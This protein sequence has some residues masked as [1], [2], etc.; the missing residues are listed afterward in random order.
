MSECLPTKEQRYQLNQRT[1][2]KKNIHY[3]ATEQDEDY[4]DYSENEVYIRQTQWPK[5][6]NTDRRTQKEIAKNSESKKEIRLRT[7]TIPKA[8]PEDIETEPIKVSTSMKKKNKKLPSIIDQL[9]PYDI[10]QDLLHR[11][12]QATYGQLL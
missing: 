8:E 4:D 5:P 3:A 7:R 1:Q 2:V 9:E 11:Q 6:Y 12:A 10:S